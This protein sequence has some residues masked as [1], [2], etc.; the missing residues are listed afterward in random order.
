MK[1]SVHHTGMFFALTAMALVA[2]SVDATAPEEDDSNQVDDALS[3]CSTS[4]TTN[5]YVGSD[6]WGT[7]K[8]K[9]TGSSPITSP[10][11]SFKVPSGVKCDF[12]ASGWKHTQSGS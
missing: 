9:N 2:C 3:A 1:M 8:L 7:I 4:I 12:D 11:I 6:Y 10:T 5:T